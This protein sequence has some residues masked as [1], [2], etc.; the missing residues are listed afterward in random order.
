MVELGK[1]VNISV[2]GRIA[3]VRLSFMI[4]LLLIRLVS[5]PF[6][7]NILKLSRHPA[8]RR[9]ESNLSQL[10]FGFDPW[11]LYSGLSDR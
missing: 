4:S 6:I 10:S 7:T 3:A 8:P 11:L 5:I 2:A 1:V 9:S